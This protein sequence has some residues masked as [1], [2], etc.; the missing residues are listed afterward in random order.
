M[1]TTRISN[2]VL[3]AAA[4]AIGSAGSAFAQM[5]GADSNRPA[6]SSQETPRSEMEDMMEQGQGMMPGNPGMM[7]GGMRGGN[8]M[9]SRMMRG[10]P[11]MGMRGTMMKVMFAVADTDGDGALSFDEVTA[12]HKRIFDAVDTDN[13]GKVTP[14]ELRTFWGQ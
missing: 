2:A 14:D 8:M 13:D 9:R 5:S 7:N 11:M 10:M 12:M 3:L 6:N 1:R 4:V